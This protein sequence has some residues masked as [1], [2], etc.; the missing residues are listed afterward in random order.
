MLRIVLLG[1]VS[2]S[3]LSRYLYPQDAKIAALDDGVHGPSIGALATGLLDLGHQLTIVTHRRGYPALHLEGHNVIFHRVNSRSSPRQQILDGFRR[4][5]RDM[6]RLLRGVQAD[7]VHAQWTY[8]WGLVALRIA[9]PRVVTI[10]DAP[11]T[12]LQQNK[13]L[14]WILRYLMAL[15]FRLLARNVSLLAVSP[16]V[17]HRWSKELLWKGEVEV[18]PNS[19]LE[20]EEAPSRTRGNVM[21]FVEV[22]NSSTLKN[23]RKLI[24]AF[25]IVRR[26]R[27]NVRLV[28]IG[29]GLGPDDEL[30]AWARQEDVATGIRFLG[31]MDQPEVIRNL[32]ESH[33]HVHASM[34]E[35]F[36]LTLVES[37]QLGLP[38]IAGSDSGATAW[39]LEEGRCG[40]LTDMRNVKSI[41]A[42][43]M[44]ALDQEESRTARVEAGRLRFAQL[45][46][47]DA[48]ARAH[49]RHY[50][51]LLSDR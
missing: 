30:A 44:E 50:E 41:A 47:L 2:P 6:L 8:E 22:A 31:P 34:E 49:A 10:H 36:G 29:A 4:E 51:K 37:L 5:R 43:M 21:Q 33:V 13:S 46:S 19:I 35:S 18:I 25:N 48:V 15:R 28:L 12:V 7:L 42:A 9:L 20:V 32:R 38:V 16:Y 14:Y 23:V 26:Q 11:L 27:P 1:P 40:L 24:L 17:A 39:V 3:A 45:Y